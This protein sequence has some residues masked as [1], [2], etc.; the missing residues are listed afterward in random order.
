M[1]GT[2]PTSPIGTRI[3]IFRTAHLHVAVSQNG[4]RVFTSPYSP[5]S[6]SSQRRHCCQQRGECLQQPQNQ[7]HPGVARP[8]AEAVSRL[9]PSFSRNNDIYIGC[10]SQ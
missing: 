2:A 9:V 4:R 6:V 10:G 3:G 5:S 1:I 7:L 8:A